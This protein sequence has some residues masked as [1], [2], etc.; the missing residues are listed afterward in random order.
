VEVLRQAKLEK[1]QD[2][3][4]KMEVARR[5]TANGQEVGIPDMQID[6]G[7]ED[8]DASSEHNGDASVADPRGTS[9]QSTRKTKQQRRKAAQVLEEKR[10]AAERA[11]QKRLLA[12]VHNIKSVRRTVEIHLSKRQQ[13]VEERR[14]ARIARIKCG[15]A[16]ERF[17]KFKVAKGEI[18][19]QLGDELVE[20]LRELKPEGNLF[21]DR[22]LNLQHRGLLEPRAR[23]T[24]K[25]GNKIKEYEKHAWK[26]FH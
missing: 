11:V 22:Y 8:T 14:A 7:M 13:L 17:G 25:R 4:A 12:S 24:P 15:L 21:R 9:K 18:D 3:K 6:D 23:V 5:E 26:R 2:V 16:G 20:S 10:A 19:V 1:Y